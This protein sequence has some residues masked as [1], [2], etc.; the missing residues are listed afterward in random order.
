MRHHLT[1]TFAIVVCVATAGPAAAH[2]FWVDISPPKPDSGVAL[3]AN[4]R[5][6][7]NLSGSA[8][9]YVDTKIKTMAHVTP[10]SSHPIGAQLGDRPAITGVNL[11]EDG[12]HILSVETHPAY[13]VF[14]TMP[15]FEEYLAYEGLSHIATLH[16]KRGLAETYI[17]EEYIRN[18][19]ALVQ[20]GAVDED[21]I[22]RLTGMPFE[23]IVKGSPFAIDQDA[24]TV[25]LEWQGAA[26]PALQITMFHVSSDGSAPDDTIQIRAWTDQDGYAEF[27]L[28]GAGKYLLNAVRM[29][30]VEGLGSV[31][32]Q[33]HWASLAFE[34]AQ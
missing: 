24:L 9:P 2:E 19:R 12:L 15:E 25:R 32:W 18:A 6:G 14:E 22:D 34:I 26:A 23:I 17:A 33:S 16:R 4:L 3:T 28:N 11:S 8:L 10:T 27:P 13:I 31:V 20:M 7:Q 29:E 1:R 5:V 30:P 21:D